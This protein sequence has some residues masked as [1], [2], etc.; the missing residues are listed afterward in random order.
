MKNAVKILAHLPK[1]FWDVITL[2][3]KMTN[4]EL[5]QIKMIDNEK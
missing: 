1:N 5:E 2:E 3:H 4:R